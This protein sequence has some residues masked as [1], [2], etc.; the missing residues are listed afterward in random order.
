M[1]WA[2]VTLFQGII[3]NVYHF[4]DHKKA[5]QFQ[6][7]WIINKFGS[8]Q[9]YIDA[10]EHSMPNDEIHIRTITEVN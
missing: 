10:I 6:S 4:N 5:V 7:T 3:E 1:G 8:I 2:C 9:N